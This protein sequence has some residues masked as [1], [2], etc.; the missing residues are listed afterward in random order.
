MLKNISL[1]LITFS[2]IICCSCSL[3]SDAKKY[4]EEKYNDT[5]TELGHKGYSSYSVSWLESKTNSGLYVEVEK[6]KKSK[7]YFDNY[8]VRYI[9][10]ILSNNIKDNIKEYVDDC[11]VY[12]SY[13]ATL[14]KHVTSKT[15]EELMNNEEETRSF[16]PYIFVEESK[17]TKEDIYKAAQILRNNFSNVRGTFKFVVVKDGSIKNIKNDIKKYQTVNYS[18]FYEYIIYESKSISLSPTLRLESYYVY[19]DYSFPSEQDFWEEK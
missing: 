16:F 2:L 4:L 9:A 15:M 5:F 18:D 19:D 3:S 10:Y 6:D 13:D 14:E 7:E 17:A 8:N 11:Y 1:L 12:S